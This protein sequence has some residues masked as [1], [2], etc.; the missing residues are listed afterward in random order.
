MA[1][2]CHTARKSIGRQPTGQLVPR[3]VPLLQEPQ[4]DSPQE[5]VSFEIVVVAP[6]RQEPQGA[7]V[8]EP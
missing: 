3:D 8:E 6:E 7:P 1:C 4:H 2:T 5:E